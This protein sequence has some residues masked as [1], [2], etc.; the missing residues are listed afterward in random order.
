[1]IRFEHTEVTGWEH[2]IRGMRNPMNSWEKSDSAYCQILDDLTK[3]NYKWRCAGCK[4]EFVGRPNCYVIGPNDYDLM[5]RLRNAGTDHRKFMRMITVYADITAPL[6]WVS[7][8]DT[9]KIGTARN[10]CSF[11]HKGTSKPFEITDFSVYDERIYEVLSPLVTKK[12]QLIYPY[13]TDEFK[14][15]SLENGR[16]YKVYKNG[17][18]F[19]EE[20]D[21]TDSTGRTRHFNEIEVKPSL[22]TNGYYE[23]NIGGR[24]GEKWLLHRLVAFCWI[25]NENKLETV[26]HIDGN[27]GNNSVENLEWCSLAENIRKGYSE[28]LFNNVG[29]LHS[30]YI[31]WKNGHTVVDPI[32]KMGILKDYE[33]MTSSEIAEKYAIT[34]EQ[35]NHVC[36]HKQS[37]ETDLFYLCYHYE[38]LLDALNT[39]R[40]EYIETRD[41]RIFFAIRQLLPQGYNIRYTWM[42]N[43]EVLANIYYSRKDHRLTEWHTFCD[44]IASLPYSEIITGG[45]ENACNCKN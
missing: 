14:I 44:W 35:A 4:N 43:Y 15:Y 31:S 5:K 17:R 7:E 10:S 33:T 8:H 20:Y 29:G 3:E 16:K 26:N 1:M 19:R 28:N 22:N 30:R 13:E 6:Y 41:D 40:D 12:Y 23:L 11:M 18:V 37:E 42:A 38:K 27:K 24:S 36:C 9:Y 2:A 32:I 25:K 34:K 45:K 39:L 21:L